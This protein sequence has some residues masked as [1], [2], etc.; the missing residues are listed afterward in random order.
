MYNTR[1]SRMWRNCRLTKNGKAKL[2]RAKMRRTSN[3]KAWNKLSDRLSVVL[4]KITRRESKA[5][6]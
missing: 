5:T 4:A 1:P 3:K 6:K 2:L